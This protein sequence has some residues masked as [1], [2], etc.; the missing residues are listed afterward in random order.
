[1]TVNGA[2]VLLLGHKIEGDGGEG[3]FTYQT[4]PAKVT[5][6]DGIVFVP[7]AGSGHF[8]RLWDRDGVRAEWFGADRTGKKAAT[9]AIQGAI[10][11]A[12][13]HRIQ[14]WGAVAVERKHQR[15]ACHR[16]AASSS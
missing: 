7:T 13:Q 15:D 1:M 4:T 2:P 9:K 5:D 12:L 8:A 14:G 6:D 11:Y 16:P 3:W 10:D